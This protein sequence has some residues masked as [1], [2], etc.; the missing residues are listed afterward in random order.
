MTRVAV[1]GAAAVARFLSAF[2]RGRANGVPKRAFSEANATLQHRI[3]QLA[4]LACRT[5]ASTRTLRAI[6][7]P[8]NSSQIPT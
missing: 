1:V 5:S 3:E 7:S 2:G 8:L 4:K 6:S